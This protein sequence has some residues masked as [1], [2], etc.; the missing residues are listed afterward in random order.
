MR[1]LEFK[2]VAV[3]AGLQ[4]VVAYV[5]IGCYYMVGVPIGALLGYVA[6]LE[7]KVKF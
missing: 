7:V 4:S 2:G 6:H 5:N 3:G 1:S